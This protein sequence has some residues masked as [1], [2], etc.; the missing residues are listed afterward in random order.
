M[1][2]LKVSFAIW[3]SSVSFQFGA[4][5]NVSNENKISF[6]FHITIVNEALSDAV[7]F[8]D[9]VYLVTSMSMRRTEKALLLASLS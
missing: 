7:Q 8:Q 6:R 1:S 5:L 3:K 9:G 4:I 2:D